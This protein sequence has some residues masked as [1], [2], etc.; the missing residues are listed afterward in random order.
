MR[1]VSPETAQ[2]VLKDLMFSA[3]QSA[4]GGSQGRADEDGGG[5]A[6][7]KGGPGAAPCREGRSDTL[8]MLALVDFYL[9]FL[10]LERRHIERCA[11]PCVLLA[12]PIDSLSA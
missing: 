8:K 1:Q 11:R 5:D 6:E 4:G 2:R 10:P 12:S 9:P 7:E 3:W